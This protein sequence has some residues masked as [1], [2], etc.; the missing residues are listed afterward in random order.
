MVEISSVI[1]ASAGKTL[2]EKIFK[3]VANRS[4]SID[5]ILSEDFNIR[6]RD[7]I[8]ECPESLQ[9]YSLTFESKKKFLLPNKKRIRLGPV[10]R[11][12]IRPIQS[13]KPIFNAITFLDDGFEI[14]LDC[15]EPGETYILDLE[16][17]ISDPNF[18][19]SLV[20]KK[21]AQETPHNGVQ[22]YWM[23]AQLK[24]LKVL[25][26]D[27]GYVDL[28]DIDFSVDVSIYQDIKMKIP[29]IFGEKIETIIRLTQPI[30]RSD[31]GKLLSRLIHQQKQKYT[32]E[33]MEY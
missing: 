32:G 5:K 20:Y 33:E 24:H 23:A 12:N 28:R 9:K 4:T 8:I 25:Q 13:L 19:D 26:Q 7:M 2:I 29:R 22:D 1:A 18:I 6:G 17:I 30:G 31:Q 3:Q 16:Y 15:L 10:R 14:N 27:F 21:V 11:V